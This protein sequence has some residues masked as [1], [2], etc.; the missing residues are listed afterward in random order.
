Y[1][2]DNFAYAKLASSEECFPAIKATVKYGDDNRGVVLVPAGDV[3]CL[4]PKDYDPSQVGWYE[5]YDN[6]ALVADL[7]KGQKVGTLTMTYDGKPAGSTDLITLTAVSANKVDKVIDKVTGNDKPYAER[8]TMQK[9]LHYWYVPLVILV[10]L[11]FLLV[12]RN[13]I[14]RAWRRREVRIRRQRETG[15]K[16]G[17]SDAKDGYRR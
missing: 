5:T 10:S 4:L 12:I 17:R 9:I 1:G 7:K 8:T 3:N 16:R 13:L 14:Y 11:F 15:R 2:F 6:N